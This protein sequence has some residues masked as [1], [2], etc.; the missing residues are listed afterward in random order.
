MARRDKLYDLAAVG[1][2][3]K[4]PYSIPANHR[5]RDRHPDGDES[6]SPQKYPASGLYT[7]FDSVASPS[8]SGGPKPTTGPER[9][10]SAPLDV[11]CADSFTSP[12]LSDEPGQ[13]SISGQ[14]VHD[15][16]HLS[17]W[18]FSDAP[19]HDA[20]GKA[21]EVH[22][23]DQS[24]LGQTLDPSAAPVLVDSFPGPGSHDDDAHGMA[25]DAHLNL[26]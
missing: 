14:R 17:Q 26:E 20:L 25:L 11:S 21:Q 6:T 24:L 16:M 8:S 23:M 9:R 1:D 22:S 18:L 10:D 19:K 4:P 3:L 13:E 15:P 2:L 7:G 5:K 12:S